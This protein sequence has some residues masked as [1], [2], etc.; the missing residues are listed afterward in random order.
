MNVSDKL[1]VL[2]KI[3]EIYAK[4]TS[5]LDLACKK[6]CAHCCTTSVILTTLEGYKIFQT[7]LSEGRI[8][9][10]DKIRQASAHRT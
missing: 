10:I 7:L 3:Y 1:T 4:F 6:Y 9:W 8:Q 5:S 2:D